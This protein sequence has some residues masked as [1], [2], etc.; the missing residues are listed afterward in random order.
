MSEILTP[1]AADIRTS[2]AFDALMWALSF[3]GTRR[4]LAEPGVLPLAESLLDREATFYAQDAELAARLTRTGARPA[5][6]GDAEYVFLSLAGE[7]DVAHAASAS[8]GTALYPDS[9][10]TLF[11]PATFGAGTALR[12]KGPGIAGEAR[13]EVGGVHPAFWTMRARAARY[14]LGFDVYLVA[15]GEVVGLP[16]STRVEVI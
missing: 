9:A 1:T 12:L 3:P 5:A 6:L 11:A 14:P 4:P 16:R 13:L 2:D 15:E 10:A 7:S 8:V